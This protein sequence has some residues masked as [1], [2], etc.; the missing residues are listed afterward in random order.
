M[1]NR[2]SKVLL[3]AFVLTA[4]MMAQNAPAL[5]TVDNIS[6]YVG[7]EGGFSS[8][9]MESNSAGLPANLSNSDLYHGGL[10]VGAQSENYRIYLGANYYIGEDEFDYLATYGAGI[11]YKFNFS[12]AVNAFVGVSAG[13]T[14]GRYYVEGEATTRTVADPYLGGDI[15]FNID[16][17]N[18]VDLELGAR[19]ISLDASNTREDVKITL[20]S[21]VT[22]Y[23]SINFK[24]KMD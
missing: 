12:K 10:K 18:S 9:D 20:N 5:Y 7:I 16:L 14:N 13:L 15:G 19:L 8:L 2:L 6:S 17:G 1:K 23:A 24:W 21:M 3:T 4:P 11:Q 22:G